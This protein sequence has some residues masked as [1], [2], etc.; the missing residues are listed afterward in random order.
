MRL[1]LQEVPRADSRAD[2][3]AGR[4]KAM[5]MPMTAMTTRSSTRV[6]AARRMARIP[7]GGAIK[8]I[9]HYLAR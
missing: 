3:T 9:G 7:A 6:K 4:S 1:F 5:R 2:C 8:A